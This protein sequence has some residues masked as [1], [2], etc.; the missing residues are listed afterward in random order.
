VYIAV[1]VADAEHVGVGS[2]RVDLVEDVDGGEADL[3]EHVHE[4]VNP[5]RVPA[6]KG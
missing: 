3:H 6:Q 1:F 5:L 4:L 2:G